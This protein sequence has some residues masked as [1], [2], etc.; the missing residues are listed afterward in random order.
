MGAGDALD[1]ALSLRAPDVYEWLVRRS[2]DR[3]SVDAVLAAVR[4]DTSDDDKALVPLM[5][6]NGKA[7]SSSTAATSPSSTTATEWSGDEL[8]WKLVL[9]CCRLP[10]AASDQQKQTALEK[11]FATEESD[12]KF[13]SA[14]TSAVAV[15]APDAN[16]GTQNNK[17]KKETVSQTR[18]RR[19][20]Q[21]VF[22]RA[23][24]VLGGAPRALARRAVCRARRAATDRPAGRR[25]L[26]AGACVC[27]YVVSGCAIVHI[28]IAHLSVSK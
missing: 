7:S 1:R 5:I 10:G 21:A 23:Q 25:A 13:G 19:D 6:V 9:D 28:L 2:H 14:S 18:R 17:E 4:G 24:R 16:G 8:F 26:D 27:L 20:P 3:L 12:E 22:L 11:L 15:A